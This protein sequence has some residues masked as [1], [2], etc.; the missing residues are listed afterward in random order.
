MPWSLDARIPVTVLPDEA[1]LATALA[2][3]PPAAALFEAPPPPLP[4]GLLAAVSFEPFGAHLAGCSCCG[5]RSPAAAALERLFQARQGGA[6]AWFDRVLALVETPAARA[7]LD[8]A[9]QQD[10]ATLAHFRRAP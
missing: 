6:A 5:G 3:G 10:V 7:M 8:E 9:L 2:A 4:A 1:A